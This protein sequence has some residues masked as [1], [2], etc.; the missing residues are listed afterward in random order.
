MLAGAKNDAPVPR[1]SLNITFIL[2]GVRY[3]KVSSFILSKNLKQLTCYIN[4]P[5]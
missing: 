5:Q 4:Q 1:K 2:A 3:L